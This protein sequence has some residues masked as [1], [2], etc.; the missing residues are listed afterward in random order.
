M[1]ARHC[2]VG[3]V[4]ALV[5]TTSDVSVLLNTVLFLFSLFLVTHSDLAHTV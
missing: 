4:A 1:Y 5:Q 2:K 3:S